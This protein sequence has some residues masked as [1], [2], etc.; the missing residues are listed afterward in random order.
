MT[1]TLFIFVH[2]LIDFYALRAFIILFHDKYFCQGTILSA[3][4]YRFMQLK[5]K[6][7]QHALMISINNCGCCGDESIHSAGP[8][9]DYCLNMSLANSRAHLLHLM[10]LVYSGAAYFDPICSLVEMDESTMCLISSPFTIEVPADVSLW[11]LPEYGFLRLTLNKMSNADKIQGDKDL[12]A[13]NFNILQESIAA[14]ATASVRIQMI[15]DYFS[16]G[17]SKAHY[18]E[19]LALFRLVGRSSDIDI[20]RKRFLSSERLAIVLAAFRFLLPRQKFQLLEFLNAEE[21]LLAEEQLGIMPFAFTP[22]NLTGHYRI[23]LAKA[24]TKDRD[25]ATILLEKRKRMKT[26]LEKRLRQRTGG[27]KAD[28]ELMWLNA[29]SITFTTFE[30]HFEEVNLGDTCTFQL[31]GDGVLTVDFVD[32]CNSDLHKGKSLFKNLVDPDNFVKILH[33]LRSQNSTQSMLAEVRRLS[34][35]NTFTCLQIVALIELFP[36][37][38][39]DQYA[40]VEIA[41][42]MFRCVVDWRGFRQVIRHVGARLAPDVEYRLGRINLYCDEVV[43]PVGWWQLDLKLN[44]D[45]WLMQELVY[46]A[47]L[48]PGNNLIDFTL[49]DCSFEVPREWL[50]EVPNDHVVAFY[51]CRS[52]EVIEKCMLNGSWSSTRHSTPSADSIPPLYFIPAWPDSNSSIQSDLPSKQN[53]AVYS[54]VSMEKIRVVADCLRRKYSSA[55]TFFAEIDTDGGGELSRA[56]FSR[57]LLAVGAWLPPEQQQMLFNVIDHDR[58]G[59]ISA[60][61]FFLFWVY[62]PPLRADDTEQLAYWKARGVLQDNYMQLARYYDVRSW[63]AREQVLLYGMDIERFTLIDQP[64]LTVRTVYDSSAKRLVALIDRAAAPAHRKAHQ[65]IWG[66]RLANVTQ[67]FSP[68][69]E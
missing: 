53:E 27:N 12:C 67:S 50:F 14:T 29:R 49:D 47:S 33:N 24:G 22:N 13:V 28:V 38:G 64:A 16:R 34:N 8:F 37:D 11:K 63:Y 3:V 4:F 54:W 61:E 36:I 55:E 59:E 60:A 41:V 44:E 19:A 26:F 35:E 52:T 25:I 65:G 21:R 56:E 51:Y 20:S 43:S 46:L 66:E 48:E 17:T 6:V 57:G 2:K 39:I 31:P 58:S 10:K 30:M 23:S 18:S 32:L 42:Y 7:N 9:G 15:G 62:A 40:R 5:V 45:R 1:G 69:S 68:P